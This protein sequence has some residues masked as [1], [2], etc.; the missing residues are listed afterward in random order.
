MSKKTQ[1]IVVFIVA[2]ILLYTGISVLIQ[3]Y[4][5][6][7]YLQEFEEKALQTTARVDRIV[8][9]TDGSKDIYVTYWIGDVE[10]SNVNIGYET[11]AIEGYGIYIYYDKNNPGSV[12]YNE[13]EGMGGPILYIVGVVF[14]LVSVALVFVNA[15][16][17]RKIAMSKNRRVYRA[18]VTEVFVDYEV[19]INKRHPYRVDCQVRNPETGKMMLFR[20]GMVRMNLEPY[21]IKYVN[22]YVNPKNPR[23][24]YVDVQGA[25]DKLRKM[26]MNYEN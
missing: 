20:S 2:G 21:Q 9:N 24:Y 13:K 8:V 23:Q 1:K 5:T 22:V 12:L 7:K 14:I 17:Y 11:T 15:N 25:V 6:N 3:G 4:T 18:E 10:Y 26:G 19:K 16:L